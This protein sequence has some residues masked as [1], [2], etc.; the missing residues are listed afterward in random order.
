MSFVFL[1]SAAI[2]LLLNGVMV[3]VH[4][5][6]RCAISPNE[7]VRSA[8]WYIECPFVHLRYYLEEWLADFLTWMQCFFAP[9]LTYFHRD[10]W[11]DRHEYRCGLEQSRS[12]MG[13]AE[14]RKQSFTALMRRFTT[15][16]NEWT[17]DMQN[18]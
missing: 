14:A 2:S 8:D 17:R 11:C 5:R 15:E 16:A 7:M 9:G 6:D 13:E 18:S 1:E 10:E 3:L 4:D 12:E